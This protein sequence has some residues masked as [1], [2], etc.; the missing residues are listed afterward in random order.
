VSE[1]R[2]KVGTSLIKT[3]RVQALE[4][5]NVGNKRDTADEPDKNC[6]GSCGLI[7]VTA[8]HCR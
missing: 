5:L 3:I 2:L 4:R 8:D 1:K 7:K 6:T